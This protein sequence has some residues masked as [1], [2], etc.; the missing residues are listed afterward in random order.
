MKKR[1]TL[2]LLSLGVVLALIVGA[3]VDYEKKLDI[4][5]K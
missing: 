3:N 1:V 2:S 4:K 5:K